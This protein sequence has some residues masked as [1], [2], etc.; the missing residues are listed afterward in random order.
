MT[1]SVLQ[2]LRGHTNH[3]GLVIVR[4]ATLL[5]GLG[6]D[7]DILRAAIR[8]L[9]E[10]RVLEILSPPQRGQDL[11]NTSAGVEQPKPR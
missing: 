8:K 6:I 7:A 1:G 5:D 10:N 9:E 11:R 3:R 4:E 2:A